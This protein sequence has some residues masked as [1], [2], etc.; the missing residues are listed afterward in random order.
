MYTSFYQNYCTLKTFGT[1]LRAV[2]WFQSSL[3]CPVECV[4]IHA[5]SVIA[6][7]KFSAPTDHPALTNIKVIGPQRLAKDIPSETELDIKV[8]DGALTFIV[9]VSSAGA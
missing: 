1:L 3:V 8:K 6:H 7:L 5:V 2:F 4:S 9:Y